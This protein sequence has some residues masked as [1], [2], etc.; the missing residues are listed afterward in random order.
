MKLK[1]RRVKLDI[2]KK[3]VTQRGL[4]ALAQAAQSGCGSPISGGIQGQAGRDPGQPDLEV[5]NP[6]HGR[7]VGAKIPSNLSH[8]RILLF[9]D[10]MIPFYR[11]SSFCQHT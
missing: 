3:V 7:R 4:E 1:E 10:S 9:C 6:A 2:S 8:S 11:D 5:G